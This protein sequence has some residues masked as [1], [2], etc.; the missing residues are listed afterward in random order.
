[1]ANISF[2]EETYQVPQ[3]VSKTGSG[4]LGFVV[5]IG[6]AKDEKEASTFLLW[7]AIAGCVL[8]AGLFAWMYVNR[9]QGLDERDIERIIQ[10]QQQ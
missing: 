10:L 1:M 3:A 4:L 5:R 6:F 7:T 2:E 9:P 8:A